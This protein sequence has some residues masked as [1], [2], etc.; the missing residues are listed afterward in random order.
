MFARTSG[1]I[2]LLLACASREVHALVPE[3]PPI[4]GDLS[5]PVA[6]RVA[7]NGPTGMSLPPTHAATFIAKQCD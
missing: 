1:S 6:L 3:L 5:T 2:V 7:F 4:P